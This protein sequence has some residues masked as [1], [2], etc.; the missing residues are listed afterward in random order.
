MLLK[1]ISPYSVKWKGNYELRQKEIDSKID[2]INSS[3]KKVFNKIKLNVKIF[4]V[5]IVFTLILC[6]V[7]SGVGI[8]RGLT[9]SA[10]DI[11]EENIMPDG[12]P[13]IIYDA[14]GKKVQN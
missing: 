8:V 11:N 5:I 4:A 14:N 13:S 2:K 1:T 12:Y 9:D 10:P 3:N 6:A 7:F